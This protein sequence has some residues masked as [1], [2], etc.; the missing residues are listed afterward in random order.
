MTSCVA[1]PGV[2]VRVALPATPLLV[3]VMFVVPARSVVT[4]PVV[5]TVATAEA[6]DVQTTV[7]SDIGALN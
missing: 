5:D 2:T 6:E 4:S 3:A 7:P 1:R